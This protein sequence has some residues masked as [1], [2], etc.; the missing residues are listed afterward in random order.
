MT[1]GSDKYE[2]GEFIFLDRIE[3][4]HVR[5]TGEHG[6]VIS[7]S[8]P[9]LGPVDRQGTK[10]YDKHFLFTLCCI[11]PQH[12]YVGTFLIISP[13]HAGFK[14]NAWGSVWEI[15]HIKAMSILSYIDPPKVL[16]T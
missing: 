2:N 13:Y 3:G 12:T 4:H 15:I 10:S 16:T 9:I 14:S 6:Y 1:I 8:S 11:C 5:N 7:G